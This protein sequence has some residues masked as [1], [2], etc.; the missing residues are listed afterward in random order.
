MTE[1]SKATQILAT[2]YTDFKNDDEWLDFMSY[3]D[4]GLPL[5]YFYNEGLCEPTDE[6][7]VSIEET[8]LVFLAA[9]GLEDTGFEDIYA[10]LKA[11]EAK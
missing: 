1:F 11:A 6:G 10:V 3:N 9:L 5:S 8:W 2:L 7:I 4:I